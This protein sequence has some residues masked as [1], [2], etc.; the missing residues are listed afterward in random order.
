FGIMQDITERKAAEARQELLTHELEHRI[1]NI[2]AM[3]SAIATQTLRNT[4]IDTGREALSARLS[5]LAAAH[6]ILTR[7][8]WTN[9]VLSEVVTSATVSLRADRIGISGPRVALEP[10]MAL[11]LALAI[12]ELGTNA[13]KYGALSNGE[14][15][16]GIEWSIDDGPGT[17]PELVWIWSEQGGPPV[18]EPTRRGFG[19]F[20]IERVLAAD[21]R[22]TVK[23]Q[24]RPEGL[25]CTLRAPLPG[26]PRASSEEELAHARPL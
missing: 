9:A 24:Y 15:R 6:D 13:L 11:S 14:G 4:D 17:V 7:T 3:V 18:A 26:A 19:R 2:L 5:A 23:L 16:V 12:N 10:K 8:R 1:K 21:F 20:L 22:G 25:V